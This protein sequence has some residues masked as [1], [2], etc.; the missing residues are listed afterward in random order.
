[1]IYDL[2]LLKAMHKHLLLLATVMILSFRTDR[3]GQTVQ[4]Q[5]RLLLY[6]V[7]NSVCIFWMHYSMVKPSCSNFRVITTN[8]WGVQMFRHFTV[9]D[10]SKLVYTDKYND[11]YLA[12][13]TVNI[14]HNT[15]MRAARVWQDGHLLLIT[16]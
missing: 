7:Y 1:M 2:T 11:K 6:T 8:F 3:S 12:F 15:V 9:L 16:T 10:A 5:I 14:Q 13:Q 4:T